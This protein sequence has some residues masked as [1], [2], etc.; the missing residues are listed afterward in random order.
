MKQYSQDELEKFDY[1]DTPDMSKP[2]VVKTSPEKIAHYKALVAARR[3]K[4][5]TGSKSPTQT[6]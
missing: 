3:A 5:Q 1:P 6:A 2:P 4:I